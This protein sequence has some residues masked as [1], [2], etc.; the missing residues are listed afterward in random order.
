MLHECRAHRSPMSG[1]G[2]IHSIALL[3]YLLVP[4]Q[5]S[6]IFH[7]KNQMVVVLFRFLQP[8]Q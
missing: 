4:R 8:H 2:C 6:F 7:I 3:V 5:V 1:M